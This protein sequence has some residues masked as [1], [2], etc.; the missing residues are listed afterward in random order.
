MRRSY[1]GSVPA[2]EFREPIEILEQQPRD[3]WENSQGTWI[4]IETLRAQ[5]SAQSVSR[6]FDA[7]QDV[8][9]NRVMFRV[10]RTL[11]TK[12]HRIRYQGDDYEILGIQ[13]IGPG[14]GHYTELMCELVTK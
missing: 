7:S 3:R 14:H 10:R 8:A 5:Y 9:I 11:A 1:R 2:G 13:K 4:T 12:K 6:K